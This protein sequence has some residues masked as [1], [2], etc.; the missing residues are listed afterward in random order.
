MSEVELLRKIITLCFLL[1]LVLLSHQGKI[2]ILKNPHILKKNFKKSSIF[3]KPEQ[4]FIGERGAKYFAFQ[5]QRMTVSSIDQ[6]GR[7]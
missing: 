1:F 2:N 4:V 6:K 7:G 5:A 3:L